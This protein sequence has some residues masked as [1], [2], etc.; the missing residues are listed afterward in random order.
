MSNTS[1]D[2]NSYSDYDNRPIRPMD[3]EAL[4][5]ALARLPILV[6]EEESVR[7]SESNSRYVYVVPVSHEKPIDESLVPKHAGSLSWRIQRDGRISPVLISINP[8]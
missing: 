2:E 3:E 8:S 6:D 7:H 5:E 1:Q 4:T